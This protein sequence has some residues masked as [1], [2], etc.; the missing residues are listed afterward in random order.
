MESKEKGVRKLIERNLT[1]GQEGLEE[2]GEWL[3][4]RKKK[5]KIKGDDRNIRK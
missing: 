5:R 2:G 3:G 1:R 4:K